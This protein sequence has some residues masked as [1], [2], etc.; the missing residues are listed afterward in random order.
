MF[1][2]DF[3]LLFYRE[4]ISFDLQEALESLEISFSFFHEFDD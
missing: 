3:N 1:F 2:Y 4:D